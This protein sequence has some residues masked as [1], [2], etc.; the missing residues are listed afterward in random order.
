MKKAISL[1][2]S[3]VLICSAMFTASARTEAIVSLTSDDKNWEYTLESDK[4]A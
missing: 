2:L 4:T 3:L 1:I